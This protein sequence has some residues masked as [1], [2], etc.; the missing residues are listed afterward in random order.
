MYF[1][2]NIDPDVRAEL[3]SELNI[4]T[5]VLSDKYLRQP[6]MVGVDRSDSFMYLLE[7]IIKRLEGW[8]EKFLSMGGKEILLKAVI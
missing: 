5:E 8:K 1:T 7:R 3:C 6:A 2:P 4:M